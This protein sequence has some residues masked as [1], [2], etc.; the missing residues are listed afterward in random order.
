MAMRSTALILGTATLLTGAVVPTAGAE[1]AGYATQTE[2]CVMGVDSITAN[3]NYAGAMVR[4]TNPPTSEKELGPKGFDAGTVKAMTEWSYG[5]TTTESYRAGRVIVGST[6]YDASLVY[7]SGPNPVT[8]KSPIGGGWGNYT[9]I[10]NAYY[11]RYLGGPNPRSTF[12]G[13]RS[14]GVINRWKIDLSTTRWGKPTA[15]AGF[16][17]V[18]AMALIAETATYDSF[19]AVTRGGA[20]YTIRIPLASS[21]PV[22]K[23]VRASGWSSFEVILAERCG[24]YGTL[25]TGI[26]KHSGSAYLYAVG[27]ANGTSTVIRSLG[28]LPGTHQD[29]VYH[30]GTN[31]SV[32]PLNG[33]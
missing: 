22:V 24:N 8:R 4:A 16:S 32:L 20:L 7:G 25:L 2:A 17:S 28:K 6:L 26:D 1:P 23:K 30:L 15:F 3:G 21:P 14:D 12:Y 33:E 5:L 19:L 10:E 9:Y 29:P 31:E 18:K 11:T 27:H 13:L